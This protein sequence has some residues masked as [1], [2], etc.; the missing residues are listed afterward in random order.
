[1]AQLGVKIYSILFKKLASNCALLHPAF[2]HHNSVAKCPVAHPAKRQ[3]CL[4]QKALQP[5]VA[6]LNFCKLSK[7]TQANYY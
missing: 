1:M 2:G 6:A 4:T 3:N 5:L 7:G